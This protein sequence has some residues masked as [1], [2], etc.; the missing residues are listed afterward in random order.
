MGRQS[1]QGQRQEGGNPKTV[2]NVTREVRIRRL[3]ILLEYRTQQ[4]H[5]PHEEQVAA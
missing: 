4:F 3:G 1:F 5:K 2:Q